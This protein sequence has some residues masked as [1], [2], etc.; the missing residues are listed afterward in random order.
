MKIKNKF[1]H[2]V[3]DGIVMLLSNVRNVIHK[4]WDQLNAVQWDMHCLQAS[5]IAMQFLCF[6][7]L[8]ETQRTYVHSRPRPARGRSAGVHSAAQGIIC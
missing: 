2:K 3:T 1:Q 7:L 6:G 4:M 8:K 5:L